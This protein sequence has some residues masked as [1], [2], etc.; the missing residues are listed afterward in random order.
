M[1]FGTILLAVGS[2]AVSACTCAFDEC[3]T[4]PTGPFVASYTA[5]LGDGKL[6][7]L[8]G[9]LELDGD[10]VYLIENRSEGP[11]R[12]WVIAFPEGETR[13]DEDTVSHDGKAYRYGTLL[14]VT[15]TPAR[16]DL[17]G[18]SAPAGCKGPRVW[19]GTSATAA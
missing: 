5:P 18:L 1:L 11:A 10:C 9:R 16:F 2:I 12:K 4:G 15:G 17:D 14:E 8:R 7:T 13:T 6:S 3:V 19:L